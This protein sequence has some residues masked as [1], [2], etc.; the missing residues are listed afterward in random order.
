MSVSE[1][2]LI[3]DMWGMNVGIMSELGYTKLKEVDGNLEI[4]WENTKAVAQ[5]AMYIYINLKGRDPKGVVDPK[6]Y[7][8]LVSQIIS[9]LYNYRDPK[10]GRRIIKF[11]LN[12]HDMEDIGL[13]GPNCGDIVYFM[14]EE[15][16]RTHGNGLS[17]QTNYGFS[18]RCLLMM[19]GAGFKK[20]EM[21][22]RRCKVVDVV[23]TICHVAGAPMPKD[24]EGSVIYQALDCKE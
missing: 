22:K 9:D 19:A 4:D 21:I 7:D 1:C 17:N 10:T 13:G 14:E 15:F 20:G 12:R 23:P 8:E 3:G 2:P 11:A 18:T 5:R 6:D 24:V 16:S